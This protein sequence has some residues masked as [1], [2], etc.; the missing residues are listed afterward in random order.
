M[1]DIENWTFCQYKSLNLKA[2]I[3]LSGEPT[4]TEEVQ[5]FYHVTVSDLEDLE[6]FQS[7]HPKLELAIEQINNKYGHWDFTNLTV[8]ETAS[9]DGGGCGSCSAH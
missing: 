2:F 7:E 4:S 8:T 6:V 1:I 9:D 3:S 5:Y